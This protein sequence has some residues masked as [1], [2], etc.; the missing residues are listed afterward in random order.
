MTI[1]VR[2]LLATFV[3]TAHLLGVE[4]TPAVAQGDKVQLLSGLIN[5]D[6]KALDK[7]AEDAKDAKPTDPTVKS[8]EDAL[9]AAEDK[10]LT[11]KEGTDQAKQAQKDVNAAEKTADAAAK[12]ASANTS[13]Y[14]AALRRIRGI[15]HRLEFAQKQLKAVEGSLGSSSAQ[16][17]LLKTISELEELIEGALDRTRPGSIA[18]SFVPGHSFAPVFAAAPGLNVYAGANIAFAFTRNDYDLALF[19]GSGAGFGA[20]IGARYYM[21]SGLM[22]GVE[23]GGT[24]Y[25]VKG[26]H[27]GLFA[28]LNWQLWKMAQV[29]FNT[30]LFG[31]SVTP[32][33]AVGL[34]EARFNVG[35]DGGF[36]RESMSGTVLGWTTRVG[37]DAAVSRNVTIGVAYQ[38]SR[39]D[40]RVKDEPLKADIHAATVRLNYNILPGD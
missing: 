29:G 35:F 40:G 18:A 30:R 9:D 28:N 21:A 13:G 4:C 14:R 7:A 38:F 31:T 6:L 37:V 39:F 25:G 17:I 5:K 8:A 20:Q 33:V 1:Q 26:S 16:S 22:I 10:L 23:I 36:A 12:S 34:T 27:E 24:G 15:R 11:A 32:Y 2:V 19:D 3:L